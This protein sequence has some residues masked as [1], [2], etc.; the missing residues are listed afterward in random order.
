MRH[1]KDSRLGR[2]LARSV[3]QNEVIATINGYRPNGAWNARGE[4]FQLQS[5]TCD[6]HLQET[7]HQVPALRDTEFLEGREPPT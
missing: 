1:K 7:E 4:V 3:Q 2:A 6:G 5:Q